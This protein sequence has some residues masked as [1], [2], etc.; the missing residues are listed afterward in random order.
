VVSAKEAASVERLP[1]WTLEEKARLRVTPEA[2]AIELAAQIERHEGLLLRYSDLLEVYLK[3]QRFIDRAG[4]TDDQ[5][6]E[7]VAVAQKEALRVL[8]PTKRE[9]PAGVVKTLT[10]GLVR[11]IQLKRTVLGRVDGFNQHQAARETDDG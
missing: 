3:P 7:Q 9:T 11:A 8:V 1:D 10:D 6:A 2:T 5:W 4:L